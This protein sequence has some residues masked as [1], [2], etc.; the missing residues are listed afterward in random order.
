MDVASRYSWQNVPTE[1]AASKRDVKNW[2]II[3]VACY[4]N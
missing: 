1:N 2:Q 3:V 4:L